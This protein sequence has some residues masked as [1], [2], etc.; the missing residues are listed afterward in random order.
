MGIDGI[1]V[2]M[3]VIIGADHGGFEKKKMVD[4]WLVASGYEV[5]DVGTFDLNGDD[6]YPDFTKAAVEKMSEGDRLILFCRNGFG[7]VIAANRYKKVRCGLAFDGKAV[8]RGRTD[9]DINALAVPAD[10]FGI[11]KIEEMVRVFLETKFSGEEK[12]L[13]RI[14]KLSELK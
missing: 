1:L 10:Y 13:R 6:D 3:K 9:D 5:L 7:M 2:S 14:N 4:S 8:N 11:E 12:Y